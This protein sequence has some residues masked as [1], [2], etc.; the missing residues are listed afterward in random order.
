MFKEYYFFEIIWHNITFY[1]LILLC[2]KKVI[3]NMFFANRDS[4]TTRIR[5]IRQTKTNAKMIKSARN[6]SKIGSLPEIFFARQTTFK[7]ARILQIWRRKPQSGNAE[8]FL[9]LI[10]DCLPLYADAEQEATGTDLP[11]TQFECRD[12]LEQ[13]GS[14]GRSSRKIREEERQ[15]LV[16]N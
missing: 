4:K 16:K 10:Y 12:E 7:S 3:N 8:S 15:Q 1:Q 14:S 13:F 9:I 5:Q 11:L 6:P 2:K